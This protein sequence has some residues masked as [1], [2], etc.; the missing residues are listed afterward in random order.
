MSYYSVPT[1]MQVLQEYHR[2]T[3]FYSKGIY[4]RKIK[5]IEGSKLYKEHKAAFEKFIQFIKRNN[6]HIVWDKMIQILAEQHKGWFSP[7]MLSNQRGIKIYRTAV[8]KFDDVDIVK[9]VKSSIKNIDFK[10]FDDYILANK[11][12]IPTLCTDLYSGK[13]SPFLLALNPDI[14]SILINTYAKDIIDEYLSSFLTDC[15]YYRSKALSHKVLK[16][17]ANNF[18]INFKKLKTK[19][20][21]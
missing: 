15:A 7:M 14:K 12:I 20:I 18:D 1:L 3:M 5:N 4:P 17:F 19:S 8:S 16:N 6:G 21:I 9:A 2:Q 13:V 11:N 10:L